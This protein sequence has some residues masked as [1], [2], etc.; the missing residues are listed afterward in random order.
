MAKPIIKSGT[1]RIKVDWDQTEFEKNA[2]KFINDIPAEISD[3][4]VDCAPLFS[5]A[6]AR[7]TPPSMGKNSIEKKYYERKVYLLPKLIRGRV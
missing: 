2:E 7:Y 6:A 3:I 1:R 5:N 4:L